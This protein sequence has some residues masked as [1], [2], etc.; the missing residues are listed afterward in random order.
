[1][2]YKWTAW[3]NGSPNNKS[4]SGYGLKVPKADRD[5]LFNP[6]WQTIT[7][8][9]PSELGGTT[10]IEVNVAKASF[11]RGCRELISKE[12]GLWLLREGLAPWDVGCPPKIRISIREN[13][14]FR[15]EGPK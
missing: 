2:P 11:W 4:G 6:E 8:E 9:I 5:G 15:I 13:N 7:I 3:S 1:M 12:I 10:P 14:V